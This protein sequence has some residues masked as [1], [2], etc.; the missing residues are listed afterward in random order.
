MRSGL[1]RSFTRHI[2]I[3]ALCAAPWLAA[4]SAVTNDTA[5]KALMPEARHSE[6][7][8]AVYALSERYHYEQ[9]PLDNEFSSKAF[10]Q[11]LESLDPS[12]MY[13]LAEDIERF[14]PGR[15]Q[16]DDSLRT[17]QVDI[18]FRMF[19]VYQN[20]ATQRLDFVLKSLETEPDFSLDEEYEYDRTDATWAKNDAELNE[21]W[22]K[23][24]KND[25]LSLVL[26]EKPWDE[27]RDVLTKRYQRVLTR[28]TQVKPDDV[29]EIYMNSFTHILDPHS[30]YMSPRNTEEYRIQMSLS[31]DGIGASLQLIDDY[32]T[33]MNVIPGGP[34]AIDGTLKQN[35]RITA[36][37]QEGEEM[38]D[39]IGWRLDDVVQLIRG[40]GGSQVRLDILPADAAPGST[41]F[42]LE[43]TRDKI[44]LEAQAAQKKLVELPRGDKTLRIG[45]VEVP[46]FYLDYQALIEGDENYTSTTRDVRRLVEELKAD[47]IDGLVLDLRNNGGGHLREAQSLSGLFIGNGPVVQMR[48]TN[49]RIE[50]LKD[51]D[52]EVAY[53]GPMAVLVNRFSASASEIFAAA[54]QDYGRGVV[55]GQQT[56][57]KGS[58]QNLFSLDRYKRADSPG[59]GQL[60]L[61]I[62]KYY[63]VTGGSTQNR[64]VNPDIELASAIDPEM[65]GESSQKTAMPWDQISPTNFKAGD[66]TLSNELPRLNQS[67]I[68]RA[69]SDKAY[70][71]LLGEIDTFKEARER[72]SVSLNLDVRKAERDKLKAESGEDTTEL[73]ADSPG[74][75][76]DSSEDP[77]VAQAHGQIMPDLA[78]TEENEPDV[79][80]DEAA[81]I[82]ID[83]INLESQKPWKAQAV[84]STVKN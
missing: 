57:G 42:V 34:A 77:A 43:L 20:R 6:I 53:D 71:E 66:T 4:S 70:Q 26:T 5:H 45:V 28:I 19:D 74:E 68:A 61:T 1:A 49:G 32:V 64:G 58:V 69:A 33:I 47:G 35:D 38:V 79:I 46:S 63:R 10:D 37:A 7:A 65:I 39:V 24:V 3:L 80:L 36:V 76:N 29:F 48:H 12:K 31:Y 13:F 21:L 30:S 8:R 51:S 72:K 50:V 22:R 11:F 17:G 2:T 56:F 78:D 9:A 82:V 83:M 81:Q 18:A 40:P 55:V 73:S 16:L 15:F 14:E 84:K 62:A 60:T 44:K 54:I 23:R 27:I 75:P 67:H 41:Q 52:P 25:A 59:F